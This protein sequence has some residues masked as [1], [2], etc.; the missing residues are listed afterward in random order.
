MQLKL[1]ADATIIVLSN[2]NKGERC[3]NVGLGGKGSDSGLDV[4]LFRTA[5]VSIRMIFAVVAAF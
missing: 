5:P 4:Q 2:P 1:E 3:N